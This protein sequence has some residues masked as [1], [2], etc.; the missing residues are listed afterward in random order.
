[1]FSISHYPVLGNA[2]RFAAYGTENSGTGKGNGL[3]AVLRVRSTA[4]VPGLEHQKYS[5]VSD[6][7]HCLFHGWHV[8]L[9]EKR[10]LKGGTTPAAGEIAKTYKS[11]H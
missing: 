11:K 7:G 6:H 8:C 2:K 1:M 4:D 9:T 5:C 3:C 10:Y